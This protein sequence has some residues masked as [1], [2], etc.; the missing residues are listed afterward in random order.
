M[1]REICFS[2]WVSWISRNSLAGKGM[3]DQGGVY[4]FARFQH[5]PSPG[6]ADPL[7][8]SVICIGQSS[9]GEGGFK[10]RWD[11]FEGAVKN[12][13]GKYRARIYVE[14]FGT[15]LSH[16]YVSTLPCQ[17]LQK[18]FL[19]LAPCSLLDIYVSNAKVTITGN[20]EL[21]NEVNDL[22][23]KYMERKLILL[24]ALHHGYRP[25]LNVD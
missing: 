20:L 15:D 4:L 13:T 12:R 24:Y 19:E 8:K 16:L 18:A 5:Q 21:L 3:E 1:S 22:L 17:E 25:V 7:E 6:S 14:L 10:S 2:S 9:K 23:I 11:A